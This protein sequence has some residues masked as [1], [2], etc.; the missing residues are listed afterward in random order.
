MGQKQRARAERRLADQGKQNLSV[1]FS[2]SDDPEESGVE[3]DI[4]DATV[5]AGLS[6]ATGAAQPNG[7]AAGGV[8]VEVDPPE[9]EEDEGEDPI[10]ALARQKKELDEARKSAEDARKEKADA[11]ARFRADSERE[12][13]E[14]EAAETRWRDEQKKRTELEAY[15]IKQDREELKHHQAI[16]EGAY[17]EADGERLTAQRAYAEAMATAD[18]EKAAEAQVA[19]TDAIYKRNQIAEGYNRLKEQIEA[20]LPEFVREPDPAPKQVA[21]PQPQPGHD[22][23]EAWVDAANLV[24][25]DKAYLRQRK[26]FIQSN[27]DNGATLQAAATL[28]EKR[29]KLKPGTP[30]YHNFI[31]EELGLAEA[32]TEAQETPAPPPAPQPNGRRIASKRP[33]AAPVSRATASSTTT[34]VWLNETD[35]KTAQELGYSQ[36]EYAKKFKS[37]PGKGQLTPDQAGGRLMA[38]YSV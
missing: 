7:L 33:T 1:K 27:P 30:E 24:D 37:N 32:A 15:K 20:P 16:L 11:E 29:Y 25:A 28:A 3:V 9:I 5:D 4:G 17:R 18:Y 34:K 2:V 19:M 21:Q 22:P 23:F 8:E 6:P 10:E 13:T 38:R 12:R 36:E 31:D 35:I 26:E 14:R